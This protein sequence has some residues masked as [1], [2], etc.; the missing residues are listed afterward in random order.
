MEFHKKNTGWKDMTKQNINRKE[1]LSSHS[2]LQV[3]LHPYDL[4]KLIGV[5][6]INLVATLSA[7]F[8][9]CLF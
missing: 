5:F 8:V 7:K 3:F 1:I 6:I 9:H 4:L 2:N